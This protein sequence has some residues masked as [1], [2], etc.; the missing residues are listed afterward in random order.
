MVLFSSYVQKGDSCLYQSKKEVTF[1]THCATILDFIQENLGGISNSFNASLGARLFISDEMFA[2]D[3]YSNEVYG[4]LSAEVKN[5]VIENFNLIHQ[6][7]DFLLSIK[8]I[9]SMLGSDFLT[10]KW[11]QIEDCFGQQISDFSSAIQIDPRRVNFCLREIV[12]SR[13]KRSS[14]LSYLFANGQ[15]VDTLNNIVVDLADAMNSNIASISKNEAYL[16]EKE[17]ELVKR[18]FTTAKKLELLKANFNSLTF[19]MRN[20][21]FIE[22]NSVNNIYKFNQKSLN[23]EKI[24]RKFLEQ[25][26]LIFDIITSKEELVCYNEN[27]IVCINPKASWVQLTGT[28]GNLIIHVHELVPAPQETSYMSC[29]PD[30]NE[31]KVSRLH[32]SHM[33]LDSENFLVGG[34]YKIKIQDLQ[35]AEVVNKD[36][37]DLSR[38]LIQENI[39]VTTKNGQ[40]G[41]SC[42]NKELL[43]IKNRKFACNKEIIW[44]DISEDIYSA[45]GTISRSAISRFYQESKLN[46]QLQEENEF[47]SFLMLEATNSSSL[48][49]MLEA[50]NTLPTTQKVG[51]SLGVS[52]VI[53]LLFVIV[54]ICTRL[55]W[56]PKYCCG[57]HPRADNSTSPD[58]VGQPVLTDERKDSLTRR[59]TQMVLSQLG[60]D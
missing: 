49:S 2:A 6:F 9:Y 48:T 43:F 12:K 51:M 38:F 26:R 17:Q 15:E 56:S 18:S 34:E 59:A 35:K 42:L 28:G 30:W 37:M 13:P 20:R 1:D 21:F 5:F 47:D 25:S 24:S 50:L 33:S 7:D 39:F 54:I 10:L 3:D 31:K 46:L 52:G 23:L 8:G 44:T 60:R 27:E 57:P 41:I 4:Q 58:V 32:N 19:E 22:E 45:K 55:F 53:I 14:I 16:F 11:N 29:I 36:L 40:L